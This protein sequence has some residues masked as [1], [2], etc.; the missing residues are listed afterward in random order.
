[1]WIDAMSLF[2]FLENCDVPALLQCIFRELACVETALHHPPISKNGACIKAK[3]QVLKNGKKVNFDPRFNICH[4]NAVI[5]CRHLKT[6]MFS[7]HQKL[8][9][10]CRTIIIISF[11][12]RGLREK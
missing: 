3:F 9:L 2:K 12:T 4:H 5:F 1:M 6:K 11:Y 10:W 7:T 8:M